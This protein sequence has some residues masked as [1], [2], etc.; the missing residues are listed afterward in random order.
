MNRHK[1]QPSQALFEK[2]LSFDFICPHCKETLLLTTDNFSCLNCSK[3]YPFTEGLPCFIDSHCFEKEEVQYEIKKEPA[4]SKIS[5]LN[6]YLRRVP[7]EILM[8]ERFNNK[9]AIGLDIGCGVGKNENFEHLFCKVTKNLL[10][11]DVAIEA[12]RKFRKNFPDCLC[13]LADCLKL[14]FKDSTFDFVTASGL[15]HHFVGQKGTLSDLFCEV[16][17]ILK[18]GGIFIFNE[19]NLLFPASLMIHPFNRFL[20]KIKPGARGRVPYERPICFLE[21][22]KH[23]KKAGFTE[24]G[25]K[26]SSFA[27]L[28]MPE[29]LINKIIS[30]ENMVLEKS[31]WKYFGSWITI[32]GIKK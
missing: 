17:R 16:H 13:L 24:I 1:L 28:Y 21:C 2:L 10:G 23:L 22:K 30:F 6:F 15:V 27:H 7:A 5:N 3:F 26:A 8:R 31:P 20:Q 32:W 9:D 29:K 14:P 11:V 18:D 25:I 12:L 19:P 4:Y